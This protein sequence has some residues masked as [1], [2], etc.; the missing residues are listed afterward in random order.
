MAPILYLKGFIS[1]P[2]WGEDEEEG[3]F[4]KLRWIGQ[5]RYRSILSG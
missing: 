1:P 3:V 2:P 4:L 5:V